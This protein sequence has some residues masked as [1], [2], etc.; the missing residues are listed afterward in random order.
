MPTEIPPY[1]DVYF[2]VAD[3]GSAT[4]TVTRLGGTTLM[5]ATPGGHGTIAVFAGPTGAVFTVLALA[6]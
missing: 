3:V 1:W 5:P 6:R 4:E 2:A